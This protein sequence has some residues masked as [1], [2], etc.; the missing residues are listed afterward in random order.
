[1]RDG[2]GVSLEINNPPIEFYFFRE[3][4]YYDKKKD[5]MILLFFSQP[6]VLN[7]RHLDKIILLLTAHRFTCLLLRSKLPPPLSILYKIFFFWNDVL[8]SRTPC[9]QPGAL[10]VPRRVFSLWLS[11]SQSSLG[12]PPAPD[13]QLFSCF[14]RY[15]I[16]SSQVVTRYEK[17]GA[18]SISL[19]EDTLYLKMEK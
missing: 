11:N 18:S 2:G 3:N 10:N 13:Q 8:S 15:L 9:Q 19:I 4:Y 12:L 1:M 17:Y 7:C 16:S 6:S 5:L 14:S